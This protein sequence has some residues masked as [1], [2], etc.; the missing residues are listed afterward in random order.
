MPA[1]RVPP[2]PPA[3]RLDEISTHQSAVRDADQ[4]LLRYGP[5]VRSYLLVRLGSAEAADEVSQ[6]VFLAVVRGAGPAA[7]PGRGRYR[8]YLK[9]VVRNAAA[10]YLRKARGRAGPPLPPDLADPA[11]ADPAWDAEWHRCLL[12]KVRR[13]LDANQRR[14]PGNLFHTVLTVYAADPK[15]GSEAHAA[16]AARRAGRPVTAEGFRK[17]L[18]RARRRMAEVVVA[19]VAA[20]VFPRTPAA[21]ESELIETGLWPLVKDYLPPD[22]RDRLGA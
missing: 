21:V 16:A 15:A 17:Q 2:D 5:S 20:T 4:F 14:T 11:A 6:E 8:D 19:E 13:D 1:P 3:R 7:W 9:A 10:G 18:S 22:W 12:D